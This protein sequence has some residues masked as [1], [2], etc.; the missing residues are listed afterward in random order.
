MGRHVD[1][2]EK[3]RLAQIFLEEIIQKGL[4]ASKV[5]IKH[6]YSTS[7]VIK[8]VRSYVKD[9]EDLEKFEKIMA[10]NQKVKNMKN[11]GISEKRRL[12]KLK[13]EIKTSPSKALNSFY[14]KSCMNTEPYD[15]ILKATEAGIDWEVA[16]GE[17]NKFR[18][19]LREEWQYE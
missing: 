16:E 4:M 15:S 6:G 2:K 7:T 11:K 19:E 13:K 9:E 3:K 10:S 17:Y 12:E 8:Y 5:A 14:R 1:D 18:K